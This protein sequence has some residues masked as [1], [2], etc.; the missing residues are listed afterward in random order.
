MSDLD[1]NHG[2]PAELLPDEVERYLLPPHAIGSPR[3][4][5]PGHLI[6]WDE[7]PVTSHAGYQDADAAYFTVARDVADRTGN[8]L[9]EVLELSQALATG[10]SEDEKCEALIALSDAIAAC[11][12][13]VSLSASDVLELS[14]SAAE[15]RALAGKGEALGPEGDFPIADRGHLVSA[16]ARFKQGRYAGHSRAA[17]R[18]HILKNARRLGVRVDLGSDGDDHTGH[19]ARDRSRRQAPRRPRPGHPGI[20]GSDSFSSGG[21]DTGGPSGAG[22]GAGVSMAAHLA[23]IARAGG[24][25][26]ASDVLRLTAQRTAD[27]DQREVLLAAAGLRDLMDEGGMSATESEVVR[28]TRDHPRQFGIDPELAGRAGTPAERRANAEADRIIGAAQDRGEWPGLPEIHDVGHTHGKAHP[29]RPGKVT[30]G[31]RAHSPDSEDASVDHHQAVQRYLREVQAMNRTS[32][33]SPDR[34]YHDDQRTPRPH[35]P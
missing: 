21:G 29:S 22:D 2:V 25:Y 23:K 18:E 35:R 20:D 15:R 14:V 33:P 31:T 6:E 26:S 5:R 4:N 11:D 8:S 1:L 34:P 7:P 3:T 19:E 28:L 16:I 30:T 27:A 17:V 13:P 9:Q 32:H 10:N 12:V 24:R